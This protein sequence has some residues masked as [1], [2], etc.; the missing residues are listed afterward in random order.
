MLSNILGIVF[1][2][3]SLGLQVACHPMPEFR[4]KQSKHRGL[5]T[6]TAKNLRPLTRADLLFERVDKSSSLLT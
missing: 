6:S 1:L 3:F 2:R 4:D 5:V